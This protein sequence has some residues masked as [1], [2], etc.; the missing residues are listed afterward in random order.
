MSADVEHRI[1]ERAYAIWL[2][3]GCPDGHDQEHW[4]LAERQVLA[5]T[6]A[7]A[8][9]PDTLP[10]APSAP[11][12]EPVAAPARKPRKTAAKADTAK[13]ESAKPAPAPKK[14][15]PKTKAKPAEGAAEPAAPKRR[16][17]KTTE[18]A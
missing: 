5:E 11:V 3:E 18:P 15:A 4:A 10:P 1:R 6:A 12:T 17:R 14:A 9:P 2:E 13:T 8:E 16:A 7:D